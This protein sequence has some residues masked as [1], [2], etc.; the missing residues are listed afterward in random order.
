MGG[1]KRPEVGW[2]PARYGPRAAE[3]LPRDRPALWAGSAP[4]RPQADLLGVPKVEPG[5]GRPPVNMGHVIFSKNA[6]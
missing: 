2:G 6:S 4:W 5:S 3:V 1:V